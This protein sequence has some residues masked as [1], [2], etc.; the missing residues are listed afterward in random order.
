MISKRRQERQIELS[1]SVFTT[2]N[3]KIELFFKLVLNF[4]VLLYIIHS[5][6][7]FT[8]KI[9]GEYKNGKFNFCNTVK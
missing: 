2:R 7:P 1:F 8:K 4:F 9:K 6:T 3:T 5:R